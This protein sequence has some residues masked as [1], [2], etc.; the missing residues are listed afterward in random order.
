MLNFGEKFSDFFGIHNVPAEQA[1]N[2]YLLHAY[3]NEITWPGHLC[4]NAGLSL[5]DRGRGGPAC[6]GKPG[7]EF[8]NFQ[9]NPLDSPTICQ[10]TCNQH[11]Y[12]I[13][14]AEQIHHKTTIL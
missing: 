1:W 2:H 5:F 11:K 3:Q 8:F 9:R 7:G 4:N 14:H 10:K 6:G 12:K 13:C